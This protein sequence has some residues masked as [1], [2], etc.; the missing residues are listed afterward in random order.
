[1]REE[2]AGAQIGNGD[3]RNGACCENAAE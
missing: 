3:G 1:M 2:I